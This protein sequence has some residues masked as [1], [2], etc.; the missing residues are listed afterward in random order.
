[1]SNATPDG[2]PF[3]EIPND[4][5]AGYGR[6]FRDAA[7]FLYDHLH[8]LNCVSPLLMVASFG[9]ELFLKC[10]NSQ[11]VYH[12]DDWLVPLEG[13]RVTAA[14]MKKGHT[15]VP[16]L[17]ALHPQVR[18][19][20]EDA[21]A[22]NPVI[23]GKAALKDALADYDTMFVNARYPFEDGRDAVHG[24]ITGLVRLLDLIGDHV[25]D[26]PRQAFCQD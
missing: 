13:Y 7:D 21:Y 17:E 25:R 8:E 6:Q 14:P 4:K 26:L 16:L 9:I 15:L 10:L 24:S 1:M 23:Q 3:A 22:R 19:G 18:T 12:Q 11:W 2:M 5:V 20:L